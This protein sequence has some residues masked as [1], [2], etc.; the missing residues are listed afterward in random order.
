MVRWGF[1][2]I[3][4]LLLSLV[5]LQLN[6][7]LPLTQQ[8]FLVGDISLAESFADFQFAYAQ[9]P[10]VVVTI[11]VGATFGLVGSLMQQLTNN[12]LTSP[13]TMGTSSGAWL[14]LLI[15]N[16]F[17]PEQ[18]ADY[19]AMAAMSGAL[20]AFLLVVLIAGFDNLAGL[21]AI[22]AGMVVNILL[23]AFATTV[24]LLNQEYAQSVF[25]WGAGDLAQNGWE[26][27]SWLSGRLLLPAVFVLMI[28][29]RLLMLL[30][31][32]QQGAQAR[33]LP[34]VP[35]FFAL[36]LVAIWLVSASITAVGLIGF[37]G[38]I[39]PNMA[40]ALGARTP[41][42]E[43]WLSLYLGAV[44]LLITDMLAV[45]ASGWAGQLVPSGV[46]AAFIGA[47]ALI[48]FSR[49]KMQAQ[50]SLSVRL[51]E[52]DARWSR[53]LSFA[54]VTSFFVILLLTFAY[55]P[56]NQTGYFAWPTD[57]QWSLRWPRA[58]VALA[59]GMGLAVAGMVLQ[60][61]IYNPLASPDLVG[62][63]SGAT[64]AV[65]LATLLLGSG[66]VVA[67]WMIALGGSLAVL[68][69]IILLARR[70]QYAP[71]SIILLGIA[72][73]A[74][75]QAFVQFALAKGN[76]DSYRI[77]LW[78][79]GSTYRVSEWQALALIVVVS[80]FGGLIW[81]TQRWLSLLSIGREFARSRGLSVS[82]ATLWFL[83]L[84]SILCS[85]VTATIGPI[86]FVGL[87]A[88]HLAAMLGAR[89]VGQQ[90]KLSVLVGASMMLWAD[91]LGQV[92]LFPKQISAGMLVAVLGAGYFLVLL[93]LQ[94][95][96]NRSS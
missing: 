94:R 88:P 75:L 27:A 32:G 59:A 78:L 38:L 30:R 44:L 87:I 73:S 4:A 90:L 3:S 80:V 11:L 76:Q 86:G 79:S 57:Y 39:S 95:V 67:Q 10:R 53:Y 45:L 69:L 54:I 91:W 52:I 12:P 49:K 74:L 81:L 65:V 9:L 62:V 92:W 42:Q 37:I 60:R 33:G 35:V 70:H 29:P 48:W 7:E 85:A 17:F 23:G 64:F 16:I 8:W 28:A 68:L 82:M 15:L 77:M 31:L 41:R 51:P 19:S 43:L 1:A 22:I 71:A 83:V 56:E 13:L 72:L 21:P 58:V 20:L 46:T 14:A 47:P 26:W 2:L 96:K 84:V 89:Q 34:V 66:F 36:M 24:I 55:Q 50:D 63:S 40:R 18:S 5:S 61:L 93:L 6:Q 25:M